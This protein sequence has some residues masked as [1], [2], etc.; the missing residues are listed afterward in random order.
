M[1]VAILDEALNGEVHVDQ[2]ALHPVC[3][4][5]VSQSAEAEVSEAA[6]PEKNHALLVVEGKRTVASDWFVTGTRFFRYDQFIAT[7]GSLLPEM[8]CKEVVMSLAR[9][10]VIILVALVVTAGLPLVV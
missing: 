6:E 2:P 9:I 7:N 10:G 4:L 5:G 1:L 8:L 3:Y